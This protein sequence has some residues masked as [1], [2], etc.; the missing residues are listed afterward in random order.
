[1]SDRK[2]SAAVSS[3]KFIIIFVE[4]TDSQIRRK[5][6]DPP[7]QHH[8]L[9]KSDMK[10]PGIQEVRVS[11][12]EHRHPPFPTGIQRS[13]VALESP[14]IDDPGI[15]VT[16]GDQVLYFRIV[17]SMKPKPGMCGSILEEPEGV[18]LQEWQ[19]PFEGN[20]KSSSLLA[21][22]WRKIIKHFNLKFG[23]P[24]E[25]FQPGGMVLRRM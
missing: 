20:T 14:P 8:P 2:K 9:C 17:T 10:G 15:K 7:S 25:F 21:G 3:V 4:F 19:I 23:A 5:S 11:A 16:S 22:I 18:S 6:R 1:M 24:R 13:P 12:D